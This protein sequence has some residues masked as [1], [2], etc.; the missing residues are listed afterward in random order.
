M[1]KFKLFSFILVL[2][3]LGVLP[4]LATTFTYGTLTAHSPLTT[5]SDDDVTLTWGAGSNTSNS[6]QH[7]KSGY[8]QLYA[9]NELTVSVPSGYSISEI[10]F[11]MSG[12]YTMDNCKVGDVAISNNKW[13]GTGS[14]I[15]IVNKGTAQTRIRGIEVTYATSGGSNPTLSV[16]PA[17]IDFGTVE[18]GATVSAEDVTVTFANL[19]GSVSYS[20]LSGAFSATGSISSTGDKITI[21]PSTSTIGE[22][23]Q[24]LTVQSTADSK[25]ANVTV[26]MKVVEPFNGL[27]LTFPDYND[28]EV[29]SYTASWTATKSGQVWNIVNFNNN[30]NGWSLIKAGRNGNASVATV[31]TQ[32]QDHAVSEVTV[33]V[34]GV[35][36]SNIN[37]HKLYVADNASFNDA[38]EINGIPVTMATGDVVYTVP[39]D[40]RDNDLYYKLVYDCASGS[41]NGFLQISKITYA[42]AAATP[43]KTAAGLAYDAADAQKLVK[44]G[45]SLTAPTLTNPYN[46][47]ITY[48]SGNTDVIEVNSSTGAITAIKAAGKA[49][50]TAA[51]EENDTYKAGSATYTIFVATEAGTAADPLTEASAKTLIDNG[52]TLTAHV[53]GLV[54]SQNSSNF[55]VTLTN[56]FQ[57]Y[58]AKDL[59]NVAF[60]SA[61]LGA[62][63]E[64]TA[65]GVLKKF[66]STYELD[67]GC[68][69][70]FYQQAT[71]P[72]TPI[73][74][75]K[76]TAYS[77]ATALGY[78]AAPTTYDLSDHV[79]IQGVVYKVNSF[80]STNGTYNIYIK[81][82]G[83]SEDDGKFEFYKCSGL[84]QV[85][86]TVVPFAEGD[87][88]EG[89]E[90]IG[91]GVMTYYT[92]GSIW[93]FGQPNQLVYLNRPAVAVTGIDLTESTAE[94]EVGSTVTLHASVVPGNAT[95]QGIVWSVTSGNDKA[96]VQDGVVSGLAAGTAV[97]RAAS[98]EDATIYAECTVTV[99]AADPTKHT[100]TFDAT[101]DKTSEN[102]DLSITKSNVTIAITDGDGR[103]NNGTD[104]REYKN[105]VFTVSCSAGNITKIEFTC[106]SGNP[107]T[108]FADATG[109]DK[110]NAVWTGNAE[111]VSF[112][113]SN[114]QVQIT[115]LVITY[116]EDNRAESGLAWDPADDIEITVGETFTAP[117]LLNP[118]NIAA[119]DITIA[120]SNTNLATVT[121]GVV[122]LVANATGE[123]TITATFAGNTTY[124]PATVLYKI[125]VSEP[126]V[127]FDSSVDH[128]ESGETTLTKS[129]F[130]LSFTSG[131][132]DGTQAEYRLYK[133]QTM[134]LSST[135]YLIQKIEFTCT[136]GNP[137][138]GFADAT[139]LD[140]ENNQWTGESNTVELT[141]SNNQVRMTKI[142]VFYVEDP[143]AA[144]GLAWSTDEVELTLGE[145]FIA[146]NLVNPNSIAAS[147][148]TIT[149]N[150]T[151]LA[152]VT[153]GV[154]ELVDDAIGTATITATFAGNAT[155]KPASVSYSIIV[156]DPTPA[157]ITNPDNKLDWGTV[158][159]GT[160]PADKTIAITLHFLSSV[161]ADLSDPDGVFDIDNYNYVDGDV[162][163]VSVINTTT[164]GT[165][166]ATLTLSDP[167]GLADDKKIT[168]SVEIENAETP[169][170]TTSKWVVASAVADG[171]E[172]L[173][174]GIKSDVTYALSTQANNNRTAVEGSL[175]EGVFTPGAN[176][177][178][179]TLV[180]QSTGKYALRTSNGKYLYA[181]S[182]SSNHM[183]TR[184]AIGEDGAAVWTITIDD[185]NEAS[186]VANCETTN[187]RNV[188]QFNSG[189]T[190]FSCY[191]S[192]SQQPIKLYVRK[193]AVII[194][195]SIENGTVTA[196]PS[197]TDAGETVTLTATPDPGYILKSLIV[198]TEAGGSVVTVLNNTFSMPADNVV[199]EA[200]F[201]LDPTPPT[202]TVIRS[203]L[204][205]GRYYSL[206]Y[207]KKMTEIKGGTLWS[208]AGKD[209]SMA[210]LVQAEAPYAAGMPYFI[211]AESDKFE[212]VVEG[213]DATTA[214]NIN[215]LYG[216]L[217]Y[218][219]N[220][221][222]TGKGA[223]HLLK[224]N[225]LHPL[226]EA[227]LSAYKAYVI[228][229]SI[230]GGKPAATSGKQVRSMPMH[231]DTTTG[232]NELNTTETPAKVIINGQLFIL[233]GEKTYDATGRLVK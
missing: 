90:V 23:E 206:C 84:Y 56:G 81:D 222:L 133:G 54:L 180:E 114:K 159:K 205:A 170:S 128:A 201:V 198:R 163:T 175:S 204:T 231:V 196:S 70:T 226:G 117:T 145:T 74:N 157:I 136:S 60:E 212:A 217:E 16:S 31:T 141:A 194:P 203:G 131:V 30:K 169:V 168:L 177:M 20:G 76:E 66:S 63:D 57:F 183:K 139:G 99:T 182:S 144:S 72:L 215:G 122:S 35:T 103:F 42:Y 58:K 209:A 124:K 214:G 22:Y 165:H 137:I 78:A 115:Q 107:I 143:R 111:S 26:T 147:E 129:G 174:T 227:Y 210:Y 219:S 149:S 118:N 166:S 55:T 47:P 171:D 142:K 11:A 88:Q 229:G 36:A 207:P 225:E 208:F 223:T 37:S 105:S 85:G 19:T 153:N 224:N 45:G 126:N 221:D 132:L 83:T 6:P 106:N 13:S 123:A 10:A 100:V 172:V 64:V 109:L 104:Y 27:V 130:T 95:D 178:S 230:S 188:M 8:A 146:A 38:I 120:S 17:T 112:T 33:T 71:A 138:T 184:D 14:S 135:D 176:T 156:L 173:L 51:S 67:E 228:V 15:T 233:R 18:Q 200:S 46:R 86:E 75:T 150:N 213:D 154:V 12:S 185:N 199:V 49:V 102:T 181:A 190:L 127:T 189:S 97:I 158:N 197:L 187:W 87:V 40:N 68:Y 155:Y 152:T 216:S 148:I 191:A 25:S 202:Y 48:T 80:N 92:D 5:Q 110:D 121:A 32:V 193:Y 211:Y 24:T 160:S 28:S 59:N 73:A 93:E 125:T 134:T 3:I 82:A 161:D 69:L 2:S 1:N 164:L 62:G 21:T 101:V 113:A 116:K 151:D 232:L 9:N 44:V 119:A 220:A 43:Q 41:S 91:Y 79:Y 179:V 65:V 98:D 94:V 96:S 162:I 53:N 192:A 39:V 52:C 186:I 61:Y 50:I 218:L 167:D 77:V 4:A 195:S 34:A 89:D 7:N 140:K 29:S 108:G